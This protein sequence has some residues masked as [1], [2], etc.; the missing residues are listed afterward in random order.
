MTHRVTVAP[1]L[2]VLVAAAWGADAPAAKTGK[3]LDAAFLRTYAET[4]G[5]MLGRPVQ[6]RPTPDG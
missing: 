4:R 1:C 6:A 3:P 5:F 2:A